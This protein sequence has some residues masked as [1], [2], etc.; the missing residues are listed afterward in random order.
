M[1]PRA[2]RTSWPVG[3]GRALPLAALLLLVLSLAAL[4]R[5]VP[6]G[7]VIADPV[8]LDGPSADIV[9]LDGVAMAADGTGGAVYRKRVDGRVHIFVVR[10]A[11]GKWSAPVRVD[12][13][14]QYES[15]FP[16]IGAGP[17][18]RLVVVW[19]QQ[20][21][22]GTQD[23]MFSAAVDP[24][25]TSF[26]D[27]IPFDLNVGDGT[28][29]A[30]SLQMNAAGQAFV[31]YRVITNRDLTGAGVPAGYVQEELRLARYDG[32]W[33]TPAGTLLNRNPAQ[34][35]LG[36]TA[37]NGPKVAIDDTGNGLVAWQEPDDAF[38]AR[39]WARRVFSGA[40]TV[41]LPV[42][43]AK[44]PS[45]DAGIPLNGAADAISVA[46]RGLSEGAVAFRQQPSPG[47]ALQEPRAMVNVLPAA[48]SQNASAFIGP[49]L[50]DGGNDATGPGGAV[51]APDVSVSGDGAFDVGLGYGTRLLDGNGSESGP[52]APVRLDDGSSPIPP[53]GVL[54]RGEDGA[55]AAAWKIQQG[56]AQG[57][58]VLERRADGTPQQRLVSSPTAGDL[59]PLLLSG[60]GFGDAAVAFQQGTAAATRIMGTV[61][62]APPSSF[63]VSAPIDWTRATRVAISWDPPA[64]AIS[65]V[66]YSVLVDDQDVADN[67][68]VPRFTASKADLPEGRH[69]VS[70]IATDGADQPT[71]G[72]SSDV[73]VDRT[74]PRVT[75]RVRGRTLSVSVKD[76]RRRSG[77]APSA[78]K[79][80]FGDGTSAKG[81]STYK[82]RYRRGRTYRVTVKTADKAGNKRTTTKRMR[83]R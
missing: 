39:V 51:G 43:P 22:G 8:A 76:A 65:T 32:S 54:D 14:Q 15:S 67:L 64:S 19:C 81:H 74:A 71:A 38:V 40:V 29:L 34:P 31:V 49:M 63:T 13:G 70:V 30:P 58:Q 9:G 35:M 78:T 10:F 16:A 42:S 82:H 55:L 5:A 26:Q 24:G 80:T 23:R 68:R 79:V 3:F 62:D 50:V 33:W 66:T 4:T 28:D 12:N 21:G 73:L 52:A 6:A 36:P 20:Y 72:T 46:M 47:S 2:R 56:T 75:L 48:P 27:P 37:D 17:G 41:P 77:V 69:T 60:S 57:V 59:G 44:W 18:G 7:A 61:V 25:A 1:I 83:V 53:Q 45:T 11:R